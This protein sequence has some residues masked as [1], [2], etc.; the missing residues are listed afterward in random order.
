MDDS[1]S[2]APGH[3]AKV[4]ESAVRQRYAMGMGKPPLPQQSFGVT[5]IPGGGGG[6]MGSQNT[7]ATMGGSARS[8]R[9]SDRY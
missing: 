4:A 6:S 2:H 8:G 3:A 1:T 9:P 5:A 7:S